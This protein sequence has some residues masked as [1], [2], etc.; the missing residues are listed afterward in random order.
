MGFWRSNSPRFRFRWALAASLSLALIAAGCA[1][2]GEDPAQDE[3]G[4][5]D[6]EDTDEQPA[7]DDPQA[8][9]AGETMTLIVPYSTGGGYDTYLRLLSPYIEEAG[10]VETVVEN[11]EGA[12]GLQAANSLYASEGDPTQIMIANGPGFS[13]SWLIGGEGVRFEMDEFTMLGRLVSEP[14]VLGVSGDSDIEDFDQLLEEGSFSWGHTGPGSTA[15]INATVV[16][17]A[18]DLDIDTVSGF[19][20]SGEIQTALIR[21]DIDVMSIEPS[22]GLS[23]IEAGEFRP[24]IYLSDERSDLLPDVPALGERDLSE[25]E[26]E[27]LDAHFALFEVGR[28]LVGPPGLEDAEVEA[29]RAIVET[30]V[31]DDEFQAD[32]EADERPLAFASGE[33]LQELVEQVADAPEEYVQLLEQAEQ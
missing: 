31:N 17:E 28:A 21:G 24:L 32:A 6:G 1:E 5:Q 14:H 3:A 20:G 10:Q 7:E 15:V 26:Q 27:L 22:S 23:A 9:F 33:E 8:R 11:Q 2:D 16:G 4:G 29:L 19:E 13:S 18:F 12:G 30:A 25:D